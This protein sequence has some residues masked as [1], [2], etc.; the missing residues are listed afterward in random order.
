MKIALVYNKDYELSALSVIEEIVKKAGIG[1]EH[2]WTND[3][4]NI[5]NDFDLYFRLDH[6]DYKYDIPAYLRPAVFYAIDTHLKKPYKKIRSQAGH[7][8]IVF[9]AQKQGAQSL[10]R[11]TGVDCQNRMCNGSHAHPSTRRTNRPTLCELHHLGVVNWI[12]WRR[13]HRRSSW[14]RCWKACKALIVRA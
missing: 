13:V 2:F 6:G 1:Y 14:S 7:Y 8:D 9:C 5:P 12:V 11:Q 3:A 10:K 4:Q